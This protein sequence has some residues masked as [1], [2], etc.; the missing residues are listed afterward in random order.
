MHKQKCK[1]GKNIFLKNIAPSQNYGKKTDQNSRFANK[2]HNYFQKVESQSVP[3]KSFSQNFHSIIISLL[4]SFGHIFKKIH[5]GLFLKIIFFVQRKKICHDFL[6]N[7]ISLLSLKI[8][9][10]HQICTNL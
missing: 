8:I 3:E 9:I 2:N 6:E 10:I 7:L 4:L 5:L 1:Q